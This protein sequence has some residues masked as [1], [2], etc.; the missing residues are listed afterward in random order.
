LG[1]MMSASS[2]EALKFLRM[3]CSCGIDRFSVNWSTPGSRRIIIQ[4]QNWDFDVNIYNVPDLEG[5]LQ[6]A[7]LLPKSITAYF[8]FPK[9]FYTGISEEGE[10]R[11]RKVPVRMAI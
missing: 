9:W 11:Y 7:L 4:L 6:A 10:N 5:F 1:H 8:N 3:L 2:A